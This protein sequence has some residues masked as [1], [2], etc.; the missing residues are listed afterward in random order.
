[1]TDITQLVPHGE[2]TLHAAWTDLVT[3]SSDRYGSGVYYARSDDKGLTWSPAV[4][5]DDDWPDLGDPDKPDWLVS[6]GVQSDGALRALWS[7]T[8]PGGPSCARQE[9]VSVDGGQEW[10]TRRRVLSP[11]EGCLGWMNMVTDSSGTTHVV[12]IARDGNAGPD[13]RTSLYHS[14]LRGNIWL[15]PQPIGQVSGLSSEWESSGIDVPHIALGLGNR[16]DVVWHQHGVG[17]WFI[18][19]RTSARAT[20]PL[21]T[22]MP[23]VEATVEDIDAEPAVPVAESLYDVP[24]TPAR[25]SEVDQ[26]SK[27]TVSGIWLGVIPAAL[28]IGAVVVIHGR[29]MR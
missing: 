4:R 17:I 3:P 10:A 6:L 20:P 5:L 16:L 11:L 24:P 23:E 12:A 22:P 28:L 2:N 13:G 25:L 7:A 1:L 19:G 14:E 15:P 29:R 8:Y 18:E 27:T 21:A 26:P 9:R